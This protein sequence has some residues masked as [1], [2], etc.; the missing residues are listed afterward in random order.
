MRTLAATALIVAGLAG[1]AG[2]AAAQQQ[3]KKTPMQMEEEQRRRDQAEID[4]QYRNAPQR[5]QLGVPQKVDPWAN[6]RPS[7]DR[8]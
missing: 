8:K 2:P 4:R 7:K 5:Q 1:L 3:E 6:I